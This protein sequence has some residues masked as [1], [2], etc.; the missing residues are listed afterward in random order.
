[1]EYVVILDHFAFLV[2]ACFINASRH[3]IV[4]SKLSLLVILDISRFLKINM[5]FLMK[6]VSYLLFCG[7]DNLEVLT[8]LSVMGIVMVRGV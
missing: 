5:I 3:L 2:H 1:M 4:F 8:I 6:A 7:I